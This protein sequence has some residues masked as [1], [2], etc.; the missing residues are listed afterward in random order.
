MRSFYSPEITLV[1]LRP[2]PLGASC[3]C[4]KQTV[5]AQPKTSVAID[6]WKQKTH[7]RRKHFYDFDRFFNE[8]VAPDPGTLS[9]T[10]AGWDLIK[11]T[12]HEFETAVGVLKRARGGG[13][14]GGLSA[15]AHLSRGKGPELPEAARLFQEAVSI[16]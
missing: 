1:S 5:A 14:Q 2:T 8:G 7:D 16:P 12:H 10:A 3:A 11:V 9:D 15:D 13:D 6:A 4:S